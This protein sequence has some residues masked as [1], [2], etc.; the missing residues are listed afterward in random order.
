M[1]DEYGICNKVHKKNE[2]FPKIYL[3][4]IKS[5]DWIGY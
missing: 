2:H 3:F 5:Y 1:G 4:F